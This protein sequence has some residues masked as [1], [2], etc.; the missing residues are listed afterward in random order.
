[1]KNIV[2]VFTIFISLVIVSA[3]RQEPSYKIGASPVPHAEI[4]NYIKPQVQ[5]LGFDYEVV[6]FTDYHLPNVALNQDT[7]NANFFQHKPY[8]T[9]QKQEYDYPFASVGGVHLEPIGLY[10]KTHHTV[11]S[12]PDELTIILS[13]SPT[14]RPRLFD[15]LNHSNILSLNDAVTPSEL[16]NAPLRALNTFYESDKIITF[17]EVDP[18][19]L[20]SNYQRESGDLV[21]INGNYA[22][23]H[24]LNPLQDALI[25]EDGES[26]YVNLLVT[27]TNQQD[28]PFIQ[29]VIAA[30]QSEQTK[31]WIQTQYKGAVI[32]VK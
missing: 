4:L 18:A 14:D 2:T 21:L 30:L 28:D 31:E 27:K 10:S 7:I 20:Y 11:Q 13:N 22:L 29:A 6:I 24:A 1:M 25:L 9:N 19:Q 32:P 16:I 12:L 17:I 3:C 23:D 26:Q 15:L 5:A 8:L